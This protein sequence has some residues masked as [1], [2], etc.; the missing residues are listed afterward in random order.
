VGETSDEGGGVRGGRKQIWLKI[1]LR[2]AP[3]VSHKKVFWVCGGRKRGEVKQQKNGGKIKKRIKQ[4]HCR[5]V[6]N[7]DVRVCGCPGGKRDRGGMI[8]T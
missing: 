5:T 2:G 8:S 1:L 3:S 7:T 4:K 6:K